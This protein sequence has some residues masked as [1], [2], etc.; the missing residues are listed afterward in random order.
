MD[1]AVFLLN[2]SC[3]NWWL[4]KGG[5]FS[6]LRFLNEGSIFTQSVFMGK[7]AARWLMHS[8]EHTVIGVNPKHFFT[9]REGDI[10]YTVQQGSNLFGLYLLVT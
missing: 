3:F 9:L 5:T 10:A 4:R 7:N 8:L 6:H 2:Q 1:F